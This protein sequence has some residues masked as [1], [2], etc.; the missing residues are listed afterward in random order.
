[1]RV[2]HIPIIGVFREIGRNAFV[3]WLLI[4]VLN[5]LVMVTLVSGG[6]YLYW[7]VSTGNFKDSK[8][9]NKTKDTIFNEKDLKNIISQFENKAENTKQAS[10]LYRGIADPSL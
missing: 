7:Q 5:I 1:M 2:P 10:V 3:D 9:A 4:L 6:V 8:V